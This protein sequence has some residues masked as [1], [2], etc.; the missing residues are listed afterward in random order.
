M[1]QLYLYKEKA[2]IAKHPQF[3]VQTFMA[4]VEQLDGHQLTDIVIATSAANLILSVRGAKTFVCFTSGADH[5]KHCDEAVSRQAA[6]E[7]ALFFIENAG[8]P[9][10]SAL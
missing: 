6:A 1:Q 10:G 9:A 8:L 5:Q 3:T 4:V 2:L 7:T